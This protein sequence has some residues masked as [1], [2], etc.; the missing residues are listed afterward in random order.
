[1][2]HRKAPLPESYLRRNPGECRWCGKD[3]IKPDGTKR[4][5][6]WHDACLGEYKIIHW[7]T[8]TRKAVFRRDRGK[9]AECGHLCSRK[10]KD[11]WHMDHIQPLIESQGDL[12]FWRL[13]NLQTLCQTCHHAKTGREAT[14]RAAARRQSRDSE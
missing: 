3:I 9:C 14:A 2:S 4:K 10:G 13:P 12:N 1:M 6:L 11:V 8:F 5:A 7:P